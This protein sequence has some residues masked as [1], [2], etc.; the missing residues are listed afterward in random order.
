MLFG[1]LV[2]ELGCGEIFEASVSGTQDAP[3]RFSTITIPPSQLLEESFR[4]AWDSLDRT[5]ELRIS[6][7]VR[8]PANSF[9]CSLRHKFISA[10]T[11]V[12]QSMAWDDTRR[13]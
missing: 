2:D 6:T 5:G 8:C 3:V 1:P 4:I 7:V 10:S 12:K 11:I 13:P 9:G